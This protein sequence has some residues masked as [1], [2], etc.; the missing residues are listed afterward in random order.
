MALYKLAV[1]YGTVD[2]AGTLNELASVPGPQRPTWSQFRSQNKLGF[3]IGIFTHAPNQNMRDE[4]AAKFYWTFGSERLPAPNTQEETDCLTLL[5]AC[6]IEPIRQHGSHSSDFDTSSYASS[7]ST[8][9]S[10]D[11]VAI[12][13]EYSSFKLAVEA[14]D[15][16]CLFC[17]QHI[18]PRAVPLFAQKSSNV[19]K[20]IIDHHMKQAGLHSVYQVQNGV[21]LCPNCNGQ[22]GALRWYIDVSDS[23]KVV[24][25]TND[26][27]DGEYLDVMKLIAGWRTL[28]QNLQLNAALAG[29][30]AVDANN[31]LP[32]YFADDDTNTHPNHAALAFHKAACLIWKT[33][34][35]DEVKEDDAMDVDGGDVEMCFAEVVDRLEDQQTK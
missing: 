9:G 29:R 35:G 30:D 1:F 19:V 8:R 6:F 28:C 11:S 14:R 25:L 13:T 5:Y 20:N 7:P 32:V 12:E 31:E 17:W 3:L 33:A 18:D 27:N 26:P 21:F 22:F 24:N 16:V 2:I 23:R 15:Q 34:G 10:R 4:Y